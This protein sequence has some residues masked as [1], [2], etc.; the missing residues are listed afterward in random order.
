[1]YAAYGSEFQSLTGFTGHLAAAPGIDAVAAQAKFQSLTGFTGHLAET[2]I[3]AQNAAQVFQSLTGFTGHLA[4]V[5]QPQ[6][7]TAD[8]VSIPNG[9]HRPFSRKSA[10]RPVAT[11]GSFNP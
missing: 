7:G 4:G 5:R 9:L 3:L 10:M 8:L 2:M 1:M 6:R 11:P